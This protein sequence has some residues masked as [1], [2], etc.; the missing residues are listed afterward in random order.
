MHASNDSERPLTPGAAPGDRYRLLDCGDGRKLEQCG[1]V[2]VDRPAPQAMGAPRLPRNV[3]STADGRFVSTPGGDGAWSWRTE[4]P[5]SWTVEWPGCRLLARSGTGGQVGLFPEQEANWKWVRDRCR[6]AQ[7]DLS[8][9][10]LFAYTGAM[11]LQAAGTGA[12]VCHVDGARGHVQWAQEN[13]SLNG[14]AGAPIRWITDDAPGFVRR[15]IR[16]GRH[17]DGI[18]LDPPSFGR[19]PGGEVFEIKNDLAGLVDACLEL[20]SD[21]PSFVVLSAHTPGWGSTALAECLAP[22][23][24]G[25][26]GSVS[27]VDMK[28][29]GEGIE[30]ASGACARWAP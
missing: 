12:R 30:L 23:V 28:I 24:G 17:Y 25:F 18:V 15:E 9:L 4:D 7:G 27:S 6:V 21:A 16:R 8:V 10:N 11:T 22:L 26:G 29:E 1:S 20:L 2:M 13:A 19:G 3:W 14:L 5:Q